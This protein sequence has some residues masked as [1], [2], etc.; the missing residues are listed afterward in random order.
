MLTIVSLTESRDKQALWDAWDGF[1]AAVRRARGRAARQRGDTLSLSQSHLLSL[2]AEEPR[3]RIGELAEAA[4]VAP[5]TAT[6][7][8]DSLERAGVVRRGRSHEDRRAVEV[9]LTPK[10]RRL[11]EQKNDAVRAQRL[12]L[13]A[14]LSPSEREQA[15]TLLRR[16]AEA[17]DEL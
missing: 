7:M 3:A 17:I 14:S 9:T 13:E 2:L 15:E 5:P 8:L 11:L 1:F 10:G 4:G 6:R 12:A 16:L